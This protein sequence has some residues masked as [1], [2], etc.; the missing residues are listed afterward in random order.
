M[1]IERKKIL[2]KDIPER[3]VLAGYGMDHVIA[4]Y[5]LAS[6]SRIFTE[7]R[8]RKPS[9]FWYSL[10]WY[11]IEELFKGYYY[12]EIDYS[13]DPERVYR[14]NV[15]DF[16]YDIGI[17]NCVFVEIGG[18]KSISKILQLKNYEDMLAFYDEYGYDKDDEEYINWKKV[19]VDYGGIELAVIQQEKYFDTMKM[20]WWFGWDIASGCLWN[21]DLVKSIK[22]IL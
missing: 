19:Y 21:G 11:W 9:G 13:I 15:D 12:R 2:Q 1:S 8:I 16:V 10:K 14:V 3:T 6:I 20:K 5:S 18:K 7:K 22:W 17:D 4:T